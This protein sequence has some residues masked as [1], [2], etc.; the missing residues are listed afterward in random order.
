MDELTIGG[1]REGIGPADHGLGW[2]DRAPAPVPNNIKEAAFLVDIGQPDA[3]IVLCELDERVRALPIVGISGDEGVC[4]FLEM[5]H[6]ALCVTV[7]DVYR[8]L[9]AALAIAL[10]TK[11]FGHLSSH[12]NPGELWP[13]PP[14]LEGPH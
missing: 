7:G 8:E 3:D 4:G 9:G 1:Y 6:Q 11:T 2:L 13:G 12:P 14:I 10:L 5:L